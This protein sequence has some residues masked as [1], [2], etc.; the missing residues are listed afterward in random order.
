MEE[1]KIQ[2]VAISE[3]EIAKSDILDKL[4][5]DETILSEQSPKY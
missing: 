2:K 5:L 4:A 1:K 3:G